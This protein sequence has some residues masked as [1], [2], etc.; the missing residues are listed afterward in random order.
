MARSRSASSP[1]FEPTP[2]LHRA[3][4]LEDAL[5]AFRAKRARKRGLV[6]TVIPY[7]GYGSDDWI[8][9]LGRVLLVRPLSLE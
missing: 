4:R 1:A 2:T 3:A 6:P 8:R 9:V 7:S 5:H